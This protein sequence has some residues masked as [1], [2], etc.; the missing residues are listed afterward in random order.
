[1]IAILA[2]SSLVCSVVARRPGAF[3]AVTGAT[4]TAR[5]RFVAFLAAPS[6]WFHAVS[7]YPLF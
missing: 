7:V 6:T 3:K 1:M 2:I 5:A 4:G